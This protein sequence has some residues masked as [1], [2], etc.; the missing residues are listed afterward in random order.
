MKDMGDPGLPAFPKKDYKRHMKA[1]F[2][3]LG[4]PASP[5]D[6]PG[7]FKAFKRPLQ[8]FSKGLFRAKFGA[9]GL[10]AFPRAPEASQ[11]P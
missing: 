11:G 1:K 9:L 3:T 4:I 6:P 10:P 8:G 2:G 5:Q 7:L